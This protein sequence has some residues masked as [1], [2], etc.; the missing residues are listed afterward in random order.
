MT[1]ASPAD[2]EAVALV[3]PFKAVLDAMENEKIG[4]TLTETLT[5][6]YS[7][8]TAEGSVRAQETIL[9]N[10]ITDGMRH[11]AQQLTTKK[12]VLAIQNG[13]AIRAQIPA[14]EV[15]YGQVNKVMPFGN[16]LAIVDVT[17]ADILA[18]MEVS[19]HKT[20]GESGGFMQISGGRLTYDSSKII[21]ERVISLELLNE[22]GSYTAIDP[23]ATYTIAANNY[24]ASGGDGYDMFKQSHNQMLDLG[25]EDWKVLA[26]YLPLAKSIPTATEGRIIN[27]VMVK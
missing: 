5:N 1:D 16:T 20:P 6:T 2:E 24:I 15:T 8:V 17:G 7:G 26:E 9:G 19:I 23:V 11:K 13:G 27:K 25:V 22:D 10:L 18:A 14:G 4:L 21:G 12:V 3:A